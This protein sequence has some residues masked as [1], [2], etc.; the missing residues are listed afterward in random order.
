MNNAMA[1]VEIR[2]Q[3]LTL[4]VSTHYA[5]DEPMVTHKTPNGYPTT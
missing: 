3:E 1:H 4:Y 5:S 2:T